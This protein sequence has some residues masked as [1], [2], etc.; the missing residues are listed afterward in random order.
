MNILLLIG[1]LDGGGAERQF[2]QMAHALAG[3]G[4]R[5]TLVTLFPGGQYWNWVRE[6]G[7]VRLVALY[8]RRPDQRLRRAA[9][10]C[11]AAWPLRILIGTV[12]PDVVYSGLHGSNLTAWF[13]VRGMTGVHLIWGIRASRERLNWKRRLPYALC[14]LVSSTVPLIIANSQAGLEDYRRLG[15]R[16]AAEAVVPNGIDL[17]QFRPEP[18]RGAELRREW[19]VAPG[20]A[21]IGVVAR[22]APK[23]DHATFLAASA[24]VARHHPD[25]RFVCIGRGTGEQVAAL[26]C[27]GDDLGLRDRLLWAG[28]RDDMPAVYSALDLLCLPSNAGEGFPNT[29]AEAMA[30]GTPCVATDVGD[31]R[32]IVGAT[33][34]IVPPGDPEALAAGMRRFLLADPSGRP[35][36]ATLRARIVEN[37]S[38]AALVRDLE[39]LL[40]GALARRPRSRT[41][42]ANH[43]P[44]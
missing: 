4:H 20:E 13:A 35:D 27:L 10:I 38:M 17:E 9:R 30:C 14:R 7:T 44:H 41:Q 1:A 8:R 39:H 23:K 22:L 15:F 2:A 32:R 37:F 34:I 16:G 40:D 21:L 26:R 43:G 19:G 33:G 11:G 42:P 36:G 28:P 29:V 24:R 31:T 18:T 3:R 25:V 12:Q 6:R 5:V